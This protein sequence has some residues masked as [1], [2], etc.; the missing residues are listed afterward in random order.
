MKEVVFGVHVGGARNKKELSE[1]KWK[2]LVGGAEL[3]NDAAH[4]E[5]VSGCSAHLVL[6]TGSKCVK[7]CVV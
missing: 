3:A 6:S 5:A 1:G 4:E 7:T 2:N